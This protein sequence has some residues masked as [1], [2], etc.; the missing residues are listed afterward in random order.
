MTAPGAQRVQEIP[1]TQV[2]VGGVVRWPCCNVLLAASDGTTELR[3]VE[4]IGG[5]PAAEAVAA[6]RVV[7]T[8]Q[9]QRHWVV[10]NERGEQV[11]LQLFNPG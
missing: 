10:E 1:R 5:R 6:F 3:V 9:V 2:R 4:R 8:K 7:L 11:E